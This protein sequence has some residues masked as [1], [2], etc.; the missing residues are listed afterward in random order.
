MDFDEAIAE[1]GLAGGFL[2]AAPALFGIGV[3]TFGGEGQPT[4]PERP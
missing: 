2:S 3:Q 1:Q 4:R